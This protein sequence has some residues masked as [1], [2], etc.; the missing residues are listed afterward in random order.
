MYQINFYAKQKEVSISLASELDTISVHFTFYDKSQ[1]CVLLILIY[2]AF[3]IACKNM[4]KL[5]WSSLHTLHPAVS[6]PE[7]KSK[8]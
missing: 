2:L 5:A 3:Q 1:H 8:Y 7:V 4:R 6:P